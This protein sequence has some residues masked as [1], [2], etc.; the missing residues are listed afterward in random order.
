[1]HVCRSRRLRLLRRPD[2]RLREHCAQHHEKEN[3]IH[4]SATGGWWAHVETMG[5]GTVNRFVRIAQEWAPAAGAH[6]RLG[7]GVF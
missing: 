1:V 7:V 6:V 3:V 2:R 4:V 5:D